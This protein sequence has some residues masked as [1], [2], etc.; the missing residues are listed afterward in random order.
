M[1]GVLRLF[2]LLLTVCF[3]SQSHGEAYRRFVSFDWD[4]IQDAIS[5]EIELKPVDPEKK[6]DKSFV[7]KTTSASW[8]GKLFPGKYLMRLRSLDHRKVAGEWSEFTDFNVMLE[9]VKILSPQIDLVE[10]TNL[11]TEK[12]MTFTWE[13]TGGANFYEI[14]IVSSD[15]IVSKKE[16]VH[17]TNFKTSLP[18]AQKYEWKVTAIAAEDLKSEKSESHYFTL[19]GKKLISVKILPPEN[20]FVRELKWVASEEP[21]NFQV[22]L[23]QYVGGNNW[24]L[25]EN[26]ENFKEEM[27]TFNSKFKGGSYRLKVV[28]S[29]PL[30]EP[31]DPATITFKAKNGDRSYTAEYLSTLK[32]SIDRTRG[33]Y[34]TASWLITM[35]D[36]QSTYNNEPLNFTNALGGTGRLGAGLQEGSSVWGFNTIF[37]LSGIIIRKKTYLFA[38]SEA[39]AVY[40]KSLSE[41]D[42][43]RYNFGLF[44]KEFPVTYPTLAL[45]SDPISS[46]YNTS[47]TGN[48]GLHLGTEYWYSMSPKLG[49]QGNVHYYQSLLTTKALISGDNVS[50]SALQIGFLG[51]YR[52]NKKMTGLMG[53]AYRTDDVKYTHPNYLRD[54]K[55]ILSQSTSAKITGHYFNLYAEWDF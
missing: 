47:N 33:W 39:N 54:T 27:I 18:V 55:T 6:K 3:A 31:S 10:K 43:L 7:F 12:E 17:A 30:R 46:Q 40:K 19:I 4:Q 51:S 16:T 48:V 20:E 50:Y 26:F 28:S 14:E 15:K 29:A 37:D 38:S 36:Y 24:T 23:E 1:F 52:V 44:Y 41:R 35:M 42:E 49:I 5:Y 34:G 11:Q 53:Y 22:T 13:P 21:K 9:P 45:P 25:T 2:L 8:S 32:N